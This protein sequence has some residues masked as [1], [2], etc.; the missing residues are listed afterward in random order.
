M[1]LNSTGNV[2]VLFLMQPPQRKL[3]PGDIHFTKAQLDTV[4]RKAISIIIARC[5][6]N[7][8]TKREIIFGPQIYGGADVRRLYDQPGIGQVQLFLKHWTKQSVA[9]QLLVCLVAWYNYSVGTS[10]CIL[11]DVHTPLPHLESKWLAS[12]RT[13]LASTHTWIEVN[14]P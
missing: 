3:P 5:G 4:Q 8:N 9:G 1:P 6:Y 2:D 12:L 7:R 13:Y 14:D 11:E 10:R